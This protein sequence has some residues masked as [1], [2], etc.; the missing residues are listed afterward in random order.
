VDKKIRLPKDEF[1]D[2]QDVEGHGGPESVKPRGE[3]AR[4]REAIPGDDQLDQDVEGHKKPR[5]EGFESVKP[6]VEGNL[7]EDV[8]G[9]KK[10]RG[11]GN[12][13]DFSV[14]PAPPSL[15]LNRTPGGELTAD[16]DTEG[17]AKH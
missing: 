16:E 9:H 6:R 2:G 12:S 15:G 17:F 5:G 13:D 8:E 11:E 1:I 4:A 14:L 10:P 7:D 3:G